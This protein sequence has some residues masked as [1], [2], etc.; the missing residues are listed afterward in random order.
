MGD[1]FAAIQRS[2]SLAHRG[3]IK[4]LG[5]VVQS[6]IIWK[7]FDDIQCQFLRAHAHIL[8]APPNRVKGGR[9]HALIV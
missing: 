8:A 1:A 6:C 9:G 5:E 3:S 7:A 4:L 2:Q